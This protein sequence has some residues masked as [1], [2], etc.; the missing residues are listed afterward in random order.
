MKNHE[1]E[2]IVAEPKGEKLYTKDEVTTKKTFSLIE[3][4]VLGAIGLLTTG[5]IVSRV[6]NTNIVDSTNNIIDKGVEK[7]KGKFK[8]NENKEAE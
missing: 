3:G 5:V 6:S 1:A 4:I 8:K 2:V 7:V